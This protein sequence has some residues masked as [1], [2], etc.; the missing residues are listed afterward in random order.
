MSI[1]DKFSIIVGHIDEF[2]DLKK[3]AEAQ[4]ITINDLTKENTNLKAKIDN[5][6]KILATS[7]PLLSSNTEKEDELS[8]DEA[9]ICHDQLHLLNLISKERELTLEEIRK[10][11]IC[12]K[13]LAS[14]R[15][16]PKKAKAEYS[17]LKLADILSIVE[18]DDSS[19]KT[20]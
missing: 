3:F 4:Y 19:G 15:T 18:G 20:S 9:S 12:S 8:G 16:N 7:T 1:S 17:Q 2:Q 10:V 14:F 5:L 13:I 11:E 6:E